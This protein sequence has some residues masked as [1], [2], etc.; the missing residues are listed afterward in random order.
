[1]GV[2][3]G[4]AL[5]NPSEKK[6]EVLRI[7]SWKFCIPQA[8]V[9]SGMRKEKKPALPFSLSIFSNAHAT[10]DPTSPISTGFIA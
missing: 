2:N 7:G 5:I 8:G 9:N 4:M 6:C 1:M 10:A 3:N